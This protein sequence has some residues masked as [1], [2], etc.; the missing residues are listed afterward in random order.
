MFDFICVLLEITCEV[1]FN[2]FLSLS[3]YEMLVLTGCTSVKNIRLLQIFEI[4]LIWTSTFKVSNLMLSFMILLQ[5]ESL[6]S[7]ILVPI[8]NL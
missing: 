6:L 2:D 1:Y 4:Y 5:K 7:F 8:Y 3:I